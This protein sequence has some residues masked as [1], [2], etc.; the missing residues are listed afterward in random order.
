MSEPGFYPPMEDLVPHRGEMLLIDCVRDDTAEYLRA[1]ARVRRDAWYADA[2]GNMPGWIGIELMAQA[3]AAFVGLEKW[4]NGKP[5]TMGFLLGTRKY[6]TTVPVFP[7]DAL[8]EVTVNLMYRETDG[9]GAFGC[10]IIL[11]GAQVAE[12]TVKVFEP[13]DPEKFMRELSA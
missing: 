6:V 2:D 8:V 10:A 7:A 3:I 11:A 12:A 9:L 1:E 5:I 13:E 4:R